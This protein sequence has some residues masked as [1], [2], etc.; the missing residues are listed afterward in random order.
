MSQV[1]FGTSR[2]RSGHPYVFAYDISCPRRYRKVFRCLRYWRSDGQYSVH[3][4][5]LSPSEL[6]ELSVELTALIDTEEDKLLA[7]RLDT[8]GRQAQIFHPLLEKPN[9]IA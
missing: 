4:T 3:E 2:Y 5:W 9:V 6:H 1:D 8:A 7:A